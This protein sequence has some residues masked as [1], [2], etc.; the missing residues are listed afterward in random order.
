MR[1]D[2]LELLR[3]DRAFREQVRQQLLTEDLLAVPGRVN[4]LTELTE[5]V[6]FLLRETIGVVR[7]LAEAQ[8]RTEALIQQQ[9]DQIQALIE[10]QRRTEE[11]LQRLVGWQRGEAGRRDGERYEREIAKRAPA[12]FNGGQG[13]TTDQLWVQ[14]Q[15]T[16]WL[17]PLLSRRMFDAEED[18][19][20]ADLIWWKGKQI[21]VVEISLQVNGQDVARAARR[22]ETLRRVGAQALAMVIGETWATLDAEDQAMA[23]Q[24]EWK[25]GSILSEG[26]LAFRRA[27]SG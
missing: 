20:L 10:V 24:V 25:V 27:S 17:A 23:K 26:F 14:Q 11:E 18:P 15:L 19:F 13:G 1:E 7:D 5:Q 22:T 9:G 4:Y 6:L 16:K 21:A 2:F 8:R 3:T 12:L